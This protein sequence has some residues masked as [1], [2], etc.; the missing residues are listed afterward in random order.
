[1]IGRNIVIKIEIGSVIGTEIET[2]IVKDLGNMK[3]E[4][5]EIEEGGWF[6]G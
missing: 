6:L 2:R 4:V 1:V 5:I 3:V